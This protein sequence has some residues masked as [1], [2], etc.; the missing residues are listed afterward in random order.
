MK[1]AGALS[2]GEMNELLKTT[3]PAGS[4]KEVYKKWIG[5]RVKLIQSV[6]G[7]ESIR[8]AF[9]LKERSLLPSKKKFTLDVNGKKITVNKGD[10]PNNIISKIGKDIHKF[11]PME[12]PAESAPSWRDAYK[13]AK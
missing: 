6:A 13:G 7:Q 8:K 2:E 10:D 11:A 12:L 1:A 9:Y 5:A 3:P 4:S